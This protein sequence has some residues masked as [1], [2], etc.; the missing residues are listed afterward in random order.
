MNLEEKVNQ[1]IKEAMKAK[2]Q[3][4]LRSLRAIKAEILL[5][6]TSGTH[7]ELDDAARDQDA[8]EDGETAS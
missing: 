4:A 2:D 3:V 6:K 8:S 1:Q 5:F 7:A